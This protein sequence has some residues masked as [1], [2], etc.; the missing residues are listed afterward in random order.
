MSCKLLL[1][2]SYY[3]CTGNR[4]WLLSAFFRLLW[5]LF[6]ITLNLFWLLGNFS[7]LLWQ[8]FLIVQCL[9]RLF[10]N[11]SYCSVP[12]SD[13]SVPFLIALAVVSDC[14]VPFSPFP[15]VCKKKMKI[16]K[17]FCLHWIANCQNTYLTSKKKSTYSGFELLPSDT[18]APG[19]TAT[20][21]GVRWQC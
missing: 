14:S 4:L 16:L 3:D 1:D 12:F 11:F 21:S 5:Q 2:Q 19:F 17:I 9:F 13:C 7:R 15:L 20:S 18:L 6:P 10:C 8:S